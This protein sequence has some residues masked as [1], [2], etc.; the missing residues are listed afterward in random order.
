MGKANDSGRRYFKGL[1][2]DDTPFK[3]HQKRIVDGIIEE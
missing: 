1:F 3:N 2:P